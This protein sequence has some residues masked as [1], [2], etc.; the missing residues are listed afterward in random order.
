MPC[1]RCKTLN[2][3][4]DMK[5]AKQRE[6]SEAVGRKKLAAVRDMVAHRQI[7]DEQF[8]MAIDR[9]REVPWGVPPDQAGHVKPPEKK[10]KRKKDARKAKRKAKA[11]AKA[12]APRPAPKAAEPV[13]DL[14]ALQAR[15]KSALAS[16]ASDDEILDLLPGDEAEGDAG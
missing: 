11:K 12:A 8:R 10:A 4:P 6:L 7:S 9:I 15:E 13:S 16:A 2:L 5:N 3:A 14:E 1:P